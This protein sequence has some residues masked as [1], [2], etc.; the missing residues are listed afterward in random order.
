MSNGGTLDFAVLSRSAVH[1]SNPRKILLA[2]ALSK[3]ARQQLT[4]W[5]VS[6][7]TGHKRLRAGLP[8]D[9][10]VGNKTGSGANGSAN[11]IAVAWPPDRAPVIV[12]AYLTESS[13]PDDTRNSVLAEVGRVAAS[14]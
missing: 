4:R 8:K 6:N 14:V 11:D 9:W 5:L 10:R 13:A 2:D 1:A 3:P 12:T 7:K